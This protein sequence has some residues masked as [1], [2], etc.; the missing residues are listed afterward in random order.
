VRPSAFAVPPRKLAEYLLNPA[1]PQG[2]A[3]A[4][5]FVA[6]GFR[7]DEPERLAEA[8]VAHA[9]TAPEARERPGFRGTNLAFAGPLETPSGKR[10]WVVAGRASLRLVLVRSSLETP[11]GKRPWVVSVWYLEEGSDT[12]RLVTAYP[13][14]RRG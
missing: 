14:R 3:K 5:F 10:P 8:L 13:Q 4:A 11:S 7:L 6:H 12:A 1:H 2:R 9:R